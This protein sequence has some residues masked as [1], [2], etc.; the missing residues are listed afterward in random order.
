MDDPQ[1]QTE[2]HQ[3]RREGYRKAKVVISTLESVR[4][5]VNCKGAGLALMVIQDESSQCAEGMTAV[6]LSD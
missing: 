3:F 5:V 4:Q 2:F 6:A 1:I